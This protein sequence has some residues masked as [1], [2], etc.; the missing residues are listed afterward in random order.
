[1]FQTAGCGECQPIRG[2][3]SALPLRILYGILT[4]NLC[5]TGSNYD[6]RPHSSKRRGKAVMKTAFVLV[7]V[8]STIFLTRVLVAFVKEL[9]LEKKKHKGVRLANVHPLPRT[10]SRASAQSATL[11]IQSAWM[12]SFAFALVIPR[13]FAQ[14]AQQPQS[15]TSPGPTTWQYGG[16]VDVGYLHDF[17]DPANHLFRSRG[18]TFHVNELNLNMTAAYLRK[19]PTESS[20]WGIVKAPR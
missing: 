19:S 3:Y 10:A 13:V 9:L 2:G 11:K 16:F 17:N 14:D 1:M 8:V 20:R 18:T 15:A 5:T 6:Q 7:G 12:I 4:P